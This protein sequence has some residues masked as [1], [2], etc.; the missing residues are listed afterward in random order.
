MTWGKIAVGCRIAKHPEALFFTSW[1]GLIAGGLRDGDEI[2]TPS[3]SMPAHWASDALAR[4]F[5]LS[6]CDSLLMID[7][8]MAFDPLDLERLRTHEANH[9][10]DI[11]F[12]FCTTRTLPPK[13]VM[14]RLAAE[15][16]GKFGGENFYTVDR[17]TDGSV[18]PVDAVGLAFTLIKRH[19]FG[20]MM[21][22]GET[23]NQSYFFTY[24]NGRETDDIPFCRRA[25]ELGFTMGVDTAVKIEHIGAIPIGWRH[26][27][28]ETR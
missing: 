24:G 16:P 5:L 21:T 27:Q 18:V 12:A 9:A 10:Y 20:A 4:A 8:D 14:M 17:F 2:L 23:I 3:T 11:T 19:V 7:D 22:V 1:T 28:V 25:R 26:L 13:P 6:E 15:Q